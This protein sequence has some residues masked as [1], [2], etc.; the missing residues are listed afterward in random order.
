[1]NDCSKYDVNWVVSHPGLIDLFHNSALRDTPNII[2]STIMNVHTLGQMLWIKKKWPRVIRV[3]PALWKNRDFQWL[4]QANQVIP[5]ELLANEFCS[6]GGQECE[7]LYRQACYN[8]QSLNIEKWCPLVECTHERKLHPE[9]W[10]MA[11]FILPQWIPYYVEKTG[12]RYYKITGRTHPAAFIY[13]VGVK[14]I[15]GKA[16]GNLLTLWGQLEATHADVDQAEE[17]NAALAQLNIAIEDIEGP[18]K[19]KIATCSATP[20]ACGVSC[21]F[22]KDLFEEFHT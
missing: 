3:C 16:S 6:M 12:V 14:Y 10:L 8:A 4:E 19:E 1:M 21:R 9:A 18:L 5:L 2:I 11:R 7:G 17:Q 22:C 13:D 15:G 20:D